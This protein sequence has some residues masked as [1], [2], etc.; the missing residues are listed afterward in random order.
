MSLRA[1]V[2]VFVAVGAMVT[3]MLVGVTLSAATAASCTVPLAG[4]VSNDGAVATVS[5]K[6]LSAQQWR[7]ARIIV[8]TGASMKVP[9]RGLVIAIATAYAE[10]ELTV[11]DHGDS[12][13][14]DSRGLFQQRGPWGPLK[15]RMDPAGSARLFFN[16]LTDT[17]GWKTMA[18]ADAAYEVQKF[19][20]ALKY[21]YAELENFATA[22]VLRARATSAS[23][24]APD[25]GHNAPAAPG[26][27]ATSPAVRGLGPDPAVSEKRVW[28]LPKSASGNNF[29][30]KG[31]MWSLGYHTGVDF[32]G[33][34]GDKIHAA[35]D[36]RVVELGN[37]GA[38]GISVVIGWKD[39]SGRTWNTRYAHMSERFANE[40]GQ[41]VAAG[42][43]I[44][45]VGA[46]GNVTGPHLH[47][48]LIPDDTNYAHAINPIPWLET[49]AL[50]PADDASQADC[51]PANGPGV[52]AAAGTL[53]G[54]HPPL[55]P[56]PP[57]LSKPFRDGGHAYYLGG[58]G[59][60]SCR[61]TGRC[62]DLFGDIGDPVHAMA[63]GVA[64]TPDY[65]SHSF[66][67][68]VTIKHR[69]GTESLYAHLTSVDIKAGPV[70]AGQ[71]IGT[72]GCSGTSGESSNCRTS[73][74]H[75]HFEWSGL[76]W[77]SGEYG[78][79]PPFWAKWPK[80][81]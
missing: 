60:H 21:R 41:P 23:A 63:D 6:K 58:M 29:G 7:N 79:L 80:K 26:T 56:V 78:Q 45:L 19:D 34:T 53:I 8:A 11:L 14:P 67:H 65:A 31:S 48:E 57:P 71:Q 35:H 69:D 40:M 10:S 43:V 54:V 5:G 27:R 15:V 47:F 44:G 39:A 4:T 68:F 28:P 2:I 9:D 81:K 30:A 49:G 1:T 24:T 70:K 76:T 62:M 73:E 12:A 17:T 13:G 77:S 66:G 22:T 46:T 52:G 36:G 55:G 37:D 59:L 18:L 3:A 32:H 51:T 33:S 20:P 38:Y 16:A 64:S 72:M 42:V 74:Q 50:E 75:L 61:F 25:D